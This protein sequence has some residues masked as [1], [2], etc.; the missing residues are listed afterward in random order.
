Q[1][2]A[3][4]RSRGADLAASHSDRAWE[5]APDIPGQP[6]PELLEASLSAD[7][8]PYAHLSFRESRVSVDLE[9]KPLDLGNLFARRRNRSRKRD[10]NQPEAAAVGAH[11]PHFRQAGREMAEIDD[12]LG[13]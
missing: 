10:R 1:V 13:P 6:R 12:R 4:S 7:L 11:G 2:S 3:R 8:R 9:L 5:N